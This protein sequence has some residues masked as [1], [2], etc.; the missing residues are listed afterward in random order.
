VHRGTPHFVI[1]FSVSF[2]GIHSLF[3]PRDSRQR[4]P[5]SLSRLT[6]VNVHPWRRNLLNSY[7]TKN[8]AAICNLKICLRSF[9]QTTSK[10]ITR[11]HSP[12]PR[13]A[14][15]RRHYARPARSLNLA[16]PLNLK[17]EPNRSSG[18]KSNC[19]IRSTRTASCDTRQ[20]RE[21]Q[22]FLPI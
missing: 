16:E 6:C 18:S 2:W 4:V 5:R 22:G 20:R 15:V 13:R 8:S 1:M 17:P 14:R 3:S 9:Q 11:V 19:C 10:S 21:T 7:Q 12:S